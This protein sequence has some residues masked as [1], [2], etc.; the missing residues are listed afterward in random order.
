MRM[1]RNI[2][3]EK[4]GKDHTE[5][6]DGRHLLGRRLCMQKKYSEAEELLRQAV[7]G[8]EKELGNDHADT[9][10][11]KYWL[12]CTLCMQEKCSEAEELLRQAVHGQEK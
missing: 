4:V 1:L 10:N 8:R 7:R 9:L 6:L 3:R 11:S 12:G 2:G 5:T